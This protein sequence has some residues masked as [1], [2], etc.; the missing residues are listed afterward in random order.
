MD[1][2]FENASGATFLVHN[3]YSDEVVSRP[4]YQKQSTCAEGTAHDANLWSSFIGIFD[5]GDITKNKEYNKI[6]QLYYINS[7]IYEKIDKYSNSRFVF[8]TWSSQFWSGDV[9]DSG[10]VNT[11][12]LQNATVPS[13]LVVAK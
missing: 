5:D 13:L 11:L 9:L 4:S 7:Q 10:A 3:I 6:I 2:A 1:S 12:Y 8:L